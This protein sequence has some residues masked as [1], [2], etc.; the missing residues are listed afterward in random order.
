VPL[1]TQAIATELI[2]YQA[3]CGL[4][5]GEAQMLAGHLEEAHVLAERALAHAR[6]HQEHGNQAYALRLLGDIAARRDPPEGEPA[7][8][9][10]QQA[11]AL[12]E[13]LGMRPLVAHCSL[14][15]GTLYARL[16]QW[17]QARTEL[18]AARNLYQAMDMTFWL[19]QV[20]AVL[21]QAEER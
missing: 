16:G 4:S 18:G 17:E 6:E 1:L 15:L 2:A 3:L 10:Y 11:L 8:A 12:A 21:A 9:H 20:E 5:L 7:V 19:P 13:A 14:G